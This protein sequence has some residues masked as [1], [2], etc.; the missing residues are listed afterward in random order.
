M[1]APVTKGLLDAPKISMSDLGMDVCGTKFLATC[2]ISHTL[3]VWDLVT[4]DIILVCDTLE[5]YTGIIDTNL[6]VCRTRIAWPKMSM[7]KIF[8]V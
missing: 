1:I 8:T 2:P 3:I 4:G 5:L 7:S 6:C